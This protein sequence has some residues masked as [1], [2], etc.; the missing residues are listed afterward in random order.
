MCFSATSSFIASGVIGTIGL[1]TLR[2]VREPRSLLFAALP[3]LFALHQFTEGFVWLGL[4]GE[5][6]SVALDHTAFLF[7]LYGQGVLPLLL[8]VAVLLMEPQGLRQRAIA[9]LVAM[10]AL[11]C[12]WMVYGVIAYPSQCYVEHHSIAYRNQ[13]TS[14]VGMTLLYIAVTCGALLLSTHRVIRWFGAFN[15]AAL[16]IAQAF[17]AYAFTSVWCFFA[18]GL[19]IIIYWQFK[20]SKFDFLKIGSFSKEH[21]PDQLSWLQMPGRGIEEPYA[22][23]PEKTGT[24]RLEDQ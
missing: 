3:I 9:A 10:G 12:I 6:G 5:V 18:A 7:M 14:D 16:L 15:V 21:A 17:K 13:V 24:A 8:P 23:H 4:E 22:G 2:H 19:S 1:A 20:H 11:V